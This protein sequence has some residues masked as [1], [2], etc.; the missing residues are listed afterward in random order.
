MLELPDS[1]V[2]DSWIVDDGSSYHLFFLFASRALGDP[3]RRHRRASVGHAVSGDLRTWVRVRDALVR[4]EAD[5]FDGVATW[6]GSVV[7]HP[8]GGW[9]M[10]YTGGADTPR[11][12]VQSIG[13]ATS[14]DLHVWTK[15]P[16]N[17]VL[18]ADPRYYETLADGTWSDEAFRDPYVFADPGGRGW[19]MLVTA[20][21]DHGPLDD[22]GVIGHATSPDLMS[23]TVQ[24]PLSDPGQGFA[25]MEVLQVV[26]VA[27]KP[28]LVFSCLPPERSLRAPDRGRDCGVWLAEG[29]SV[30][31]PFDLANARPI[32]GSDRYA[33][34]LVRERES[35]EWLL[36]AFEH[37]ERSPHFGRII[38]P[39]PLRLL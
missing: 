19:H 5:D 3:S 15:S 4:G 32:T 28:T 2:W 8:D 12:V 1:W 37:D 23:W 39:E 18:T 33:G 36:L 35:G 11:G 30:V 6:T 27:G 9:V 25:Q 14:P 13:L 31:G 22:R 10:F 20:R 38:D 26:T 29:D 24:P 17:P 16:R 21:A 7:R 34:R